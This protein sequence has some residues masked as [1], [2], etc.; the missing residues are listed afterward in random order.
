MTAARAGV[1]Y[2]E[3]GHAVISMR[4]G[5]RCLYVTIVPDGSRLGHVCCENPLVGAHDDKI[6]HALMVLIAAS[7][8][9]IDPTHTRSQMDLNIP[10]PIKRGIM[11][12]NLRLVRT[13]QKKLL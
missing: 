9:D 1:A 12:Q 10:I 2:H 7:L 4:L 5:Y 8:A 13:L 11:D 3:A 6:K